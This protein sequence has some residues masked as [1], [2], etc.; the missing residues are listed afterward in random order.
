MLADFSRRLAVLI[1]RDRATG[2][3]P[4]GADAEALASSLTWATERAFH[5]AMTGHDTA[6]TDVNA[7]I[8]PLVQLHVST[9]YGRPLERSR[10]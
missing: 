8:E 10:R 9:I 2:V 6:L 3:A 7:I 4:P 1:D 5:I